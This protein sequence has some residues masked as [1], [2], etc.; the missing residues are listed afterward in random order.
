MSTIMEVIVMYMRTYPFLFVII[1]LLCAAIGLS[2]HDHSTDPK[3]E[4]DV[5][6]TLASLN[7]IDDN[8]FYTMNYYGDYGFGEYLKT[9]QWPCF[10]SSSSVNKNKYGCTCFAANGSDSSKIY[11]RNFDWTSHAALLLYTNPPDG[12]ASVSMVSLADLGYSDNNP[13][14]VSQ[15][16]NS[17][18]Q[19]PYFPVDG[20]NEYGVTVALMLVDHAEPPYNSKNQT[21]YTNIVVRLVL[22]YAKNIDEALSLIGNYNI[23]FG[24]SPCHYLIAD[25]TS[26]SVIVE[27]VN[28][29]IKVINSTE[30]W[31]VCTNFIIT[32]TQ[33]PNN[34][35]CWRY[36]TAYNL[37]KENGGNIGEN[38]AMNILSQVVQWPP[39]NTMWSIVYDLR[40]LDILVAI[41]KNYT[42]PYR[43]KVQK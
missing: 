12:C 22:D 9:G 13:P 27:F 21:I 25:S 23:N 34:V 3:T 18:L 41:N 14:D 19:A 11:G 10:F 24:N 26:R 30:K 7:K 15:D 35:T 43:F 16:K 2:C 28:G 8:L 36:N 17:L 29:E 32:G 37:L 38:E 33:T 20:M 40:S 39:Y 5:Q 42:N 31:Q 6:K 4:V 1:I